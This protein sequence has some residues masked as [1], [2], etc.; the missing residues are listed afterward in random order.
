LEQRRL[1]S[2]RFL[3]A[4]PLEVGDDVL[5]VEEKPRIG[6]APKWAHVGKVS[7]KV[8]DWVYAVKDI[9]SNKEAEYH[10][11]KL[12]PFV[13]NR[14]KQTLNNWETLLWQALEVHG[15]SSVERFKMED[16]ELLCLVHWA[17]AKK[18]SSWEK[19]RVWVPKIPHYFK[20]L[21]E[22]KE[23][24]GEQIRPNLERLIKKTGV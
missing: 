8:N 24:A 15:V 23:C 3:S 5:I 2:H 1:L 16:N 22:S 17:D 20:M 18:S 6:L 10:V 14:F 9:M 7:K 12:R 11:A 21:L 13:N 4:F 19:A